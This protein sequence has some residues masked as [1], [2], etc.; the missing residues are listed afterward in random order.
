MANSAE[1][2]SIGDFVVFAGSLLLSLG[3]GLFFAVKDRKKMS[4]ENYYFGNRKLSPI[5]VGFSIAVTFLSAVTVIA[6]PTEIYMFGAVSFWMGIGTGLVPLVFA[7]CYYIPLYFRLQLCSVYQYLELRFDKYVRKV[8]SAL[9]ILTMV[10]YMGC[11]M[12]LPA[13]ALSAVTPF[14]VEWTIALTSLICLFYTVAGGMKAVVWADTIQAVIMLVGCLA[15]FI[16]TLFLV[17]GWS[18]VYKALEDGN[19]LNL[20]DFNLDP[21]LRLTSLSVLVGTSVLGCYGVCAN[22]A[23]VQ[24]HLSCKNVNEARISAIF[25]G[26]LNLLVTALCMMNGLVM[27]AYFKGCDPIFNGELKKPDQLAPYLVL[28]IFREY[29]G[30]TGLFVS[31][32]YSGT[33]STFSS[34][35][36]ALA[37]MLLEDFILPMKPSLKATMKL[38]LSKILGILLGALVTGIAYLASSL[39]A[40]VLKISLTTFGMFAGPVLGLYTMG[41]FL[42]WTNSKGALSGV[43]AGSLFATWVAV[44]GI[45]HP[46]SPEKTRLLPLS[47]EDCLTSISLNITDTPTTSTNVIAMTTTALIVT[48]ERPLLDE[49]LY[50]LSYQLVG[51]VGFVITILVGVTFSFVTGH[52]DPSKLD[53]RL[54]MPIVDHHILP[55]KVRNFFRFGVPLTCKSIKIVEKEELVPGNTND[56]TKEVEKKPF[57]TSSNCQIA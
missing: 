27:Y 49:T 22:Q 44:G 45:L 25:G 43:L 7:C 17:G 32:V 57:Q 37:N 31:A 9:T 36:N 56:D 46:P 23:V 38:H 47:T 55:E 8:T 3:V 19:R 21:T 42:P 13:L 24:R 34:G 33:L 35:V 20:F 30:M 39:G 12:Y 14:E 41:V 53:P 40:T 6:A 52:N 28:K 51:V 4:T 2:F 11:T 10:I 16:R 26:V 54:F 50:S 48:P 18:N 15:T 5:P 1:G 29:P